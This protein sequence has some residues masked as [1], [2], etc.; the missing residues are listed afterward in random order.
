M[1]KGTMQIVAYQKNNKE[2]ARE[3]AIAIKQL[4]LFEFS[5]IKTKQIGVSW[6]SEPQKLSIRGNKLS[7]DEAV[8]FFVTK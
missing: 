8:S 4:L 3:R 2:L 1:K 6:F 5:S 7:I